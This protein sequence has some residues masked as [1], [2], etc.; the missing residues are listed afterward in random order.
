M[1]LLK[2]D[3]VEEAR[4][5]LLK[6]AAGKIPVREN[7]DFFMGCGKVL[8]ED[9]TAAENVPGFRKSTVDGY[10][11]RARDTQ[12][13]TES[14]P[15]F[16]NVTGEVSMGKAPDKSIS[17]G[18]AYY[19]PTGGML[20]DG[21]DSVVMIEYTEKFDEKSI[22]VYDSVSVGRN[23][24][25]EGEDVREGETLLKKGLVLRPQD[26][27]ALASAG[28]SKVSVFGPWKV[29]IISTGDELAEVDAE[30]RKG[31]T[32]DINTH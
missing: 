14:I 10:A 6:K 13:V 15:V 21:A 31:Q 5:K 28:V 19:V 18:Q 7:I 3:T 27:G 26:I 32:R 24:I 17:S 16:L 9:V 22:A 23:V 2:V 1:R 11:V 8:A 29:T 20:P 4:A 30:I 25:S 12:G